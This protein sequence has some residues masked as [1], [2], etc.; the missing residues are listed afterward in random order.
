MQDDNM[1]YSLRDWMI[2]DWYEQMINA[3][4]EHASSDI[5]RKFGSN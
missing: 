2:V 5:R 4:L 3:N 1:S